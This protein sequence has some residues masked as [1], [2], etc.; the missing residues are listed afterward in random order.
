MPIGADGKKMHIWIGCMA[1][2]WTFCC[3]CIWHAIFIAT[4]LATGMVLC[5][6]L[7]LHPLLPAKLASLHD[8]VR[9]A[10][11]P[12]LSGMCQICPCPPASPSLSRRAS[13]SVCCFPCPR[14]A[15]KHLCSRLPSSLVTSSLSG[16]CFHVRLTACPVHS[17]WDSVPTWVPA[18]SE[19]SQQ[20]CLP[21]VP[22]NALIP[23]VTP[24]LPVCPVASHRF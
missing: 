1:C 2:C 15:E 14:M 20:C 18:F 19:N 4:F 11:P 10:H 22:R 13:P 8:S 21:G 7:Q 9:F 6:S 16:P 23:Q 12:D 24:F 5:V 3:I 17:G